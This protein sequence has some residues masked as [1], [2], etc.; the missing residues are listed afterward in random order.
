MIAADADQDGDVSAI[1]VTGLQRY[2]AGIA[3]SGFRVG[4]TVTIYKSI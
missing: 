1:D 3:T 4:E 2:L